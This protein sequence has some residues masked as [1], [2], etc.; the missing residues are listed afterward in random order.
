MLVGLSALLIV[1]FCS[2]NNLK[3]YYAYNEKIFLNSKDNKLIVRYI[4]NKKADKK[5]VSLYSELADKEFKWIDDSTSVISFTPSEVSYFKEK[6]KR[7][8]D[9]KTCNPVYAIETGL[10]MG[11]TDEIVVRFLEE[12]EQNDIEKL[13]KKHKL[14]VVKTTHFYSL[15]KVPKGSDALEIAN[16]CQESGL[17]RFSHPNFICNAELFQKL[18]N[19]QYFINQFNLHNVGQV[20]TDGHAGTVDADIDAPEAWA[21]TKGN[22]NIVVAVIDDGVVS[23]HPDL[24][25]T[26]QVRLNGS[27]FGDGDPNSPYP[28]GNMNHGNSLAGVIA[29]TQNNN[30][31]V[32]GIAPMCKIM[33]IRIVSSDYKFVSNDKIAAAI[34]FARQNGAHIISCSWGYYSSNPNFIPIIRDAIQVATTQGRNGLGCVIVCGVGNWSNHAG[35]SN[36]FICFPA[37][38]DIPGVLTVGASDRNDLQAN[39]SPTSNPNSPNNQLL[40]IVAPSHRAYSHQ[41]SGET[42]ECWSIDLPNNFGDNPV[43]RTDGGTL[44]VIS[45][46]LPNSGVNYLSYTGRVGGTSFACAEVAG[47]AALILS[48]NPNLTQM[49]V[50]NIL[51]STANKVGGY[52][53]TNGFSNQMGY[54]R[55]NAGGAVNVA[56]GSLNVSITG[57]SM[58]CYSNST[59]TLNN[60]PSGYSVTWGNSSNIQ[61]ISGQGSTSYTVRALNSVAGGK[62]DVWANVYNSY[63][64]FTVGPK[65][66]WVGNPDFNIVS[67]AILYPLAPGIAVIDHYESNPY[68]IQGVNNVNWS[69][70]GP[71]TNFVGSL[72]KATFRAGSTAGQGFIYANAY[73]TCGS[74]EKQFFFQ[75]VQSLKMAISPNPSSNHINV[76]ITDIDAQEN[77]VNNPEYNVAIVNLYGNVVY[78]KAHRGANFNINVSNFS[79]GLHSISIER[80]GKSCSESFVKE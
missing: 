28:S 68:S 9:V 73:N 62:G 23:N 32:S 41:I 59:F 33:P 26:R 76:A 43:K 7:Q 47:V 10:E 13:I 31:G 24:P 66:V 35:G 12:A 56:Q 27:N 36:S 60:L 63:G 14:E 21:V 34:D 46:Q 67:D 64:S 69:H 20:F 57:P 54:G 70:T 37:C 17:T 44:P 65:V 75:V 30:E 39:Y 22:S 48:V 19:D 4:H 11:L 51:T 50:F 58:V 71:L 79:N 16:D 53:Y 55:L 80:N 72:Y 49:Q 52:V 3:Y 18:P 40:D 15:L 25:N 78:K 29:A 2:S 8:D 6:I 61:Y 74:T 5:L 45:S 38:V 42:L 1:V 77:N